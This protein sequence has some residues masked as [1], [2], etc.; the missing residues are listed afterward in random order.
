MQNRKKVFIIC[1]KEEYEY[2]WSRL[3][4][5]I[6]VKEEELLVPYGFMRYEV[7]DEEIMTDI[8]KYIDNKID[9]DFLKVYAR[10]TWFNKKYEYFK[11]TVIHAEK[12]IVIS[13]GRISSPEDDIEEKNMEIDG[14]KNL[15]IPVSYFNINEYETEKTLIKK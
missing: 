4:K 13:N 15:Q 2:V 7:I 5:I 12:I 11:Q 1:S 6:N 8:D 14:I 3:H 9:V 10:Q